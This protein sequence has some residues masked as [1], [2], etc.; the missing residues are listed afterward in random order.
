MNTRVGVIGAGMM[1][2]IHGRAW[3]SLDNTTLAFVHDN[4]EY[5]GARLAQA[6]EVSSAQTVTEL[7]DSVDVVSI[8]TP[9]STH[10][11]LVSA[12]ALAG[13]H[14]L[15]E[16]PS[17]R[18]L[19]EHDQ[20]ARVVRE[21]GV[22]AMVGVTG[23]F[24]PESRA[25]KRYLRNHPSGRIQGVVERVYLDDA[26]LPDWYHD[27]EVSGGGVLLT[28]GI[29]SID[30]LLWLTETPLASLHQVRMMPAA[31]EERYVDFT[32]GLR[33]GANAHVQLVWQAGA[34]GESR[35]DIVRENDTIQITT[36]QGIRVTGAQVLT[37]SYYSPDM[38]FE[39]RTQVGVAEEGRTLL[40]AIERGDEPESGFAEHRRA[41]AVIEAAFALEKEGGFRA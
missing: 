21:A 12:A 17:A 8:C 2:A 34:S 6:L 25:A 28:N 31:K 32:L 41:L 7:L 19:A 24:Y 39:D 3:H 29:H 27:P 9:P 37:E 38:T 5:R 30:R 36:W 4:D 15:L 13:V 26:G 35:L 14:I 20:I 40:E 22:T 16:K 1:G 33:D 23:R 11:D 18:N 10:K